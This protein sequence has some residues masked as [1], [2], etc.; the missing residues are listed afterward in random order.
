MRL[1][2]KWTIRIKYILNQLLRPLLFWLGKIFDIKILQFSITKIKHVSL[3]QDTFWACDLLGSRCAI[4]PRLPRNGVFSSRDTIFKGLARDT[5]VQ[6]ARIRA[7]SS[8]PSTVKMDLAGNQTKPVGYIKWSTM[9]VMSLTTKN[10]ISNFEN[11]IFWE[12]HHMV[13]LQMKKHNC[14]EPFYFVIAKI[15]WIDAFIR[16]LYFYP[17]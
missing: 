13:L 14:G 6:L 12:I 15:P 17:N 5:M 4:F 10:R 11:G 8:H 16:I 3:K 1:K 2:L 7:S 9:S